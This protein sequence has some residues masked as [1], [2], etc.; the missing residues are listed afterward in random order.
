MLPS[1]RNAKPKLFDLKTDAAEKH[2]VAAQHPNALKRLHAAAEAA[3]AAGSD[4]DTA[5]AGNQKAADRNTEALRRDAKM[6]ADLANKARD[7]VWWSNAK[8]LVAGAFVGAVAGGGAAAAGASLLGAAAL[9]PVV[10][11]VVV[12]ALL[13]SLAAW[14]FAC[15]DVPPF[16]RPVTVAPVA[17]EPVDQALVDTHNQRSRELTDALKLQR[18]VMSNI[19]TAKAAQKR[20]RDLQQLGRTLPGDCR[21]AVRAMDPSRVA[22]E[23]IAELKEA[24][25]T[26][27]KWAAEARTVAE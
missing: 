11:G 10:V 16:A 19:E 3:R 23:V 22:D 12:G 20:V 5:T 1:K 8:K 25:Q 7:A 21:M 17:V 9:G 4:V 24:S 6:A 18:R 2:N 15:D 13:G 14:C 27:R 26:L